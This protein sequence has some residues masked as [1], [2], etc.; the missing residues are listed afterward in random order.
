MH[1]GWKESFRQTR[2]AA[3][4]REHFWIWPAA[5]ATSLSAWR[6]AGANITPPRLP[7]SP[8][9][10]PP[11]N[12]DMLDVGCPNGRWSRASRRAQAALFFSRQN[13]EEVTFPSNTFDAYTIRVR[14]PERH[15]QGQGGWPRP[16]A[17]F[18]PAD[19]SSAWSFRSTELG[20]GFR[21]IYDLYSMACDAAHAARPSQATTESYRYL[22]ESIRKFPRAPE[23]ETMIRAAGFV[24]TKA[25]IILGG[26][27]SAIHSGWK[28]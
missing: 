20:R 25:E 27:L 21:E 10:P 23:F 16:T 17:C 9:P 18:G 2:E 3:A 5:P 11:P 12:Q 1:R 28:I 24:N 26:V 14:H 7:I 6:H 8:P 22:A 4:G 13:A 19:G 15:L